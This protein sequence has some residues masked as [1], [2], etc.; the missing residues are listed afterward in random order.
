MAESNP[1]PIK[2]KVSEIMK[3]SLKAGEKDLLQFARNLF[4]AIRKKEIDTRKDATDTDIH[5]LIST[6]SKQRQ[7]SIE[8]FRKGGREE[9]ATK[10]E[11]ELKFLMSFMPAQLS[12]AE[13]KTIVE[14]AVQEAQATSA[15]DM[16]K[17]MK[18]LMPKT[19][20][21]ADGRLVSELVKKA[22][23]GA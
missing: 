8:Q 1:S 22:L 13:L 9:L 17:V 19:Q 6:L 20:G 4:A 2:I 16:G 18:V 15:K 12:E 7:E 23:G 21:R 14:A 10:E 5:Q 3:S 11:A